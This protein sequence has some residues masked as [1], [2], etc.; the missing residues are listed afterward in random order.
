MVNQWAGADNSEQVLRSS[1]R[2]HGTDTVPPALCTHSGCPTALPTLVI[3]KPCFSSAGIW[4]R[5]SCEFGGY[6]QSW[7]ADFM[8]SQATSLYVLPPFR[9]QSC[10]TIQGSSVALSFST[11]FLGGGGGC[12]TE[13]T[14]TFSVVRGAVLQRLVLSIFFPALV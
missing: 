4:H 14:G 13:A 9:S 3:I 7:W 11:K 5:A 2:S 12:F 6:V 8:M 1:R 10:L